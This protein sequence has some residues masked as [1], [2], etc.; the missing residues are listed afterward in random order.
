MMKHK[1]LMVIVAVVLLAAAGATAQLV[2]RDP[3]VRGGP[4]GAG[5]ML[6]GLTPTQQAFFVASQEEFEESDTLDEG[7]GPRFNLDGCAGCHSQPATGGTSPEVN[8]QVAVATAFGARNVV[9]S[10]IDLNG[11]VREARFKYTAAGARDGRVHPLFVISGRNDGTADASGCT[12]QQENF[13][14]Q[15]AAN[16]V[17]FRIPTP[18]FGAG[19]IEQIPDRRSEERR[20]GKECRSRLWR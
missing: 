4:A 16:N 1:A 13:D 8:P 2:A 11:P 7:L 17:I 14:A 20:V 6:D 9:P 3:G 15:V 12:I 19:L 10:F 18:V 5:G